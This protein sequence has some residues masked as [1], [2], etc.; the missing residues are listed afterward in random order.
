MDVRA[1]ART[2]AGWSVINALVA[3]ERHL[4]RYR[5]IRYEDLVG[6]PRD[7]VGEILGFLGIGD[8]GLPLDED[9]GFER[10]SNH[11]VAGNPGRFQR[12]CTRIRADEAWRG[13]IDARTRAVVTGLTAPS[14]L[15][16]GYRLG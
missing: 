9:G 10:V 11:T 12:G 13:E 14:L 4:G 8:R 3:A 5:R 7:V 1:P 6:R 16:Y 15:R 2:A